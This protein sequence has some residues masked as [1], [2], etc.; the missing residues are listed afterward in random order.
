L[1]ELNQ[2]VESIYVK[3]ESDNLDYV[4]EEILKKIKAGNNYIFWPKVR[5]LLI[6]SLVIVEEN[7]SLL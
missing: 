6:K 3:E 1:K 5:N 2:L 7:I 4:H